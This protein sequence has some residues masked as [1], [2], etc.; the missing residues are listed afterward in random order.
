MFDDKVEQ[1]KALESL[2]M[3]LIKKRKE[4]VK[5]QDEL[6]NINQGEL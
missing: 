4:V 5:L 6:D 2:K 3:T 1:Q